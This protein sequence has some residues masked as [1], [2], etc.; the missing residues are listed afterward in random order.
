M[1]QFFLPIR[2]LITFRQGFLLVM[3]M[4]VILHFWLIKHYFALDITAGL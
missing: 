1:Y 4:A 3:A 2:E